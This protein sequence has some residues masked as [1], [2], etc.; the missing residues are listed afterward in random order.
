MS[1]FDYATGLTMTNEKSTPCL[2]VQHVRQNHY[3]ARHGIWLLPYNVTEEVVLALARGIAKE[4]GEK[5]F[6][7][8]VG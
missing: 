3:P 1:Y 5:T 4:T 7:W 8:Q 2:A 6:V